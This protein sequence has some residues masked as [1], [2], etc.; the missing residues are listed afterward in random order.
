MCLRDFHDSRKGSTFICDMPKEAVTIGGLSYDGKKFWVS[1][2]TVK[3][4][5]DTVHCRIT[6]GIDVADAKAIMRHSLGHHQVMAYTEHKKAALLAGQFM[7]FET[8]E[9]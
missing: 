1:S 5:E 3:W 4:V 9:I 6:V 7:G 2:G 8:R